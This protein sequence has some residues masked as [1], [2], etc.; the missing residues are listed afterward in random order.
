MAVATYHRDSDGVDLVELD[1]GSANDVNKA[2][3]AILGV[4]TSIGH[5]TLEVQHGDGSSLSLSTDGQRALLVRFD[6]DGTSYSSVGA[7]PDGP[8]L[9]FDYRGSWSEAGSKNTVDLGVAVEALTQFVE[10]G[11]VAP[12]LVGFEAD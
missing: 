1:V 11:F 3:R 4:R 6:A 9:V 7:E 2:V 12:D 8:V 5:P 10:R